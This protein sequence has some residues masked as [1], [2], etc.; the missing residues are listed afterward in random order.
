[1]H[2]GISLHAPYSV[3]PELWKLGLEYTKDH[4]LP[5]CIHVAE[6]PAE[7]EFMTKGTGA[8]ADNYYV[9]VP[10][11]PSP[12][13]SPI[14]FLADIGALEQKPLLVHCVQVDDE[15]I[16][17]IKESGSAVV[18]CPRSNLRLNSGRMPLEKF[19]AQDIPVLLGTDSLAS[20]PS[21]NIF[22]EVEVA[23]A[24]HH[25]KVDAKDILALASNT[26]PVD[27]S[28]KS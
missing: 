27:S 2:I 17:L 11:V 20:S 21:L 25:G 10:K 15:D 14:Q 9:D 5:L 16:K 28:V 7:H 26:I 24:L 12:M 8:I 6:S 19:L 13:K 22:D 4:N 3:H 18:H 23:I 1:M